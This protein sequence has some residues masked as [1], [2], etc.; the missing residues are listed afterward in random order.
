MGN[1]TMEE[2]RDLEREKREFKRDGIIE[3]YW[4]KIWSFNKES[5]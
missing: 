3:K 5:W 1:G 2:E 4:P